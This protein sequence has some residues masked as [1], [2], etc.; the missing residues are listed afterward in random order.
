[1]QAEPHLIPLDGETF[2]LRSA[3]TSEE[4]RLDIKATGFWRRG[5]TAFFDV[6]VTHVNSASNRNQSTESVFLE[7]ENEK[8]RAYLQRV[9]EVEQ[10]TFTPLVLGTNGGMGQE[11][12]VFIKHLA[13]NDA[14]KENDNYSSIIIMLRTKLSF[15]ILKLTLLCVRGTRYPW[16]KRDNPA[17]E[18]FTLIREKAEVK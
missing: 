2:D 12:A 9:I 6:R 4:A 10:G 7:N 16:K 1:M 14:E 17:M 13:E 18:D 11:C 5:Q 15:E 3:N 8:K